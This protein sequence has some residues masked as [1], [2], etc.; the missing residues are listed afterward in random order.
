MKYIAFLA[1]LS[2][3]SFGNAAHLFVAQGVCD[4]G[5]AC[6]LPGSQVINFELTLEDSAYG[7]SGSFLTTDPADFQSFF[8]S[9]SLGTTFESYGTVTGVF[10][11]FDPDGYLSLSGFDGSA[12]VDGFDGGYFNVSDDFGSALQG[13]IDFG[14]TYEGMVADRLAPVPLPAAA[15]LFGSALF[16]LIGLQRRKAKLAS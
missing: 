3:A 2:F 4:A 8:I 14:W 15:W 9:D 10:D 13:T 1:L 11:F 12:L 16:G 5:F 7:G 6:G